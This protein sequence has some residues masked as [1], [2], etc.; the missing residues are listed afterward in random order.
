[1][2][3]FRY[4]SVQS[5]PPLPQERTFK[6]VLADPPWP[7]SGGGKVRRGA[8]AHYPLLSF[9]QIRAINVRSVIEPNAHC[10]LW[11]TNRFLDEGLKVLNAWGFEYR[12]VITWVKGRYQNNNDEEIHLDRIGLG[13]YFRGCTEQLLFGVRGTLPYK[14]GPNGKRMQGRTVIVEPKR[15]HSRKPASQYEL[16]ETVSYPPFLELFARHSRENWTTWGIETDKFM[17]AQWLTPAPTIRN[18]SL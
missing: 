15:E 17:R 10:Y 6:T 14:I 2:T 16:V 13:Q 9:E 5:L 1:M 4:P 7:E 8:D 3:F 12:T 18:M 11:I